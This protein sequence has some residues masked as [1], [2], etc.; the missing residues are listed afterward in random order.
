MAHEIETMAFA[1][2][3]PWHGLGVNVPETITPAEMLVAAGLDW[4]VERIP[5]TCFDSPDHIP[6]KLAIRRATDKTVYGI[7]SDRWKPVQNIEILSFFKNWTEAGEATIETAGSLRNGRQVW[8]L[9]NL[10]TGFVLPGG[11]AVRGYVLMVGSHEAG[12]AT[13]I[14]TTTVRV[15]CANTLR[16]ALQGKAQAELR[17]SH[18]SDF[19]PEVAQQTLGLQRESISEFERNARLLQSLNLS[20]EDAVRIL[21]PVYQPQEEADDIVKSEALW[22]PTMR[23]ILWANEKAPGAVPGTAWGLLN[24]GTYF[25]D[26][27][28]GT[29]NL[30]NRFFA[31]QMGAQA[32]RKD[33]LYKS[34]LELAQ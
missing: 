32:T 20:R 25:A 22:T 34:L 19:N 24:A 13:L 29:A 30:D 18:I 3:V 6:G 7:V 4:Q 21:A 5:V 9:A 31:A 8:A 26:H 12:R 2:A 16:L 28:S 1:H 23:C 14:Q 33:H 10:K 15:V 27:M 17:W 11:D